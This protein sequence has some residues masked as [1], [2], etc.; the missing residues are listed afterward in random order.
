MRCLWVVLAAGCNLAFPLPE[1]PRSESCGPYGPATAI[2]FGVEIQDPISDLSVLRDGSRALV[3][4]N[5]GIEANTPI[6][7]VKLVNN[8]W[9]HDPMYQANLDILQLAQRVSWGHLSFEGEMFAAQLVGT[10][11]SA[12]RY[13]FQTSGPMANTWQLDPVTPIAFANGEDV[14]PFG[15]LQTGTGATDRYQYV[16]TRHDPRDGGRPYIAVAVDPPENDVWRDEVVSGGVLSTEAINKV[17]IVSQAVLA[18]GRDGRIA[19]IYAA[20]EN[21]RSQLFI[22]D[23]RNARFEEGIPIIE[24]NELGED[25][26]DPWTNPDC[27]VLYYRRRNILYRA[28]LDP[29]L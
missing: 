13:T 18:L 16:V 6:T 17:H 23:K 8:R 26:V 9:V 3:R 10:E 29:T 24:H 15:A 7:A 28:E 25:E 27:S 19:M 2:A 21:G 22:S 4:A 12:F 1:V 14:I 11:L 20:R 5:H